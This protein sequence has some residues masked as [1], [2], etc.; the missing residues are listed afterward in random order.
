MNLPEYIEEMRLTA[1]F[2][3]DGPQS[4][5]FDRIGSFCLIEDL[6]KNHTMFDAFLLELT[7]RENIIHCITTQ[8]KSTLSFLDNRTIYSF[9]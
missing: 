4:G 1:I 2:S 7:S 5:P 9:Y 3:E 8:A 6:V